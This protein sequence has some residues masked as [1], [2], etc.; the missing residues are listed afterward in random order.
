MQFEIL[1]YTIEV[2]SSELYN[3]ITIDKGDFFRWVRNKEL[4]KWCHDYNDP[5]EPDGH[6]QKTGEYSFDEYYNLPYETIKKDLI[7][8]IKEH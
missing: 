1:K 3:E 8:Y 7:K 5:G 2:F 4:N 6:G